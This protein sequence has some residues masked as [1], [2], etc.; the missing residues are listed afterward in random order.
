MQQQTSELPALRVAVVVPDGQ[1]DD[2]LVRQ[3]DAAEQAIIAQR[4]S[5]P[6]LRQADPAQ[7]PT[8]VRYAYD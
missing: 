3:W 2:V 8:R 6:V 5:K 7:E 1:P 4:L